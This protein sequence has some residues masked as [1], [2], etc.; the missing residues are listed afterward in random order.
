MGYSCHLNVN[1]QENKQNDIKNSKKLLKETKMVPL[2][3]QHLLTIKKHK[4]KK[5]ISTIKKF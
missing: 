3:I 2:Y 1:I 4:L 5:K